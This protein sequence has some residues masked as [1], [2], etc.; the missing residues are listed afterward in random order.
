MYLNLKAYMYGIF[1][2][3]I[4]VHRETDHQF[5]KILN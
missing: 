5:S 3:L 1:L 2:Y 4:I